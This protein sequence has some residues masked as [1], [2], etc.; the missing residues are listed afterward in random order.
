MELGRVG[1]APTAGI[2]AGHMALDDTALENP[3]DLGELP[4]EPAVALAQGVELLLGG[5]GH[6][7]IKLYLLSEL[8]AIMLVADAPPTSPASPHWRLPCCD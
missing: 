4:G 5:T 8:P 1:V 7:G 6:F 3:A 2:A